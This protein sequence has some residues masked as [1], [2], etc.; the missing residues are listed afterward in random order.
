MT[1][2]IRAPWGTVLRTACVVSLVLMAA[3]AGCFGGDAG[4]KEGSPSPS[5]TPTGG[6]E[7][8]TVRV[9]ILEYPTNATANGTIN[10]TWQVEPETNV[11]TPLTHTGVHY[12][13]QSVPEANETSDEE[14]PNSAGEQSVGTAPGTFNAS[15]VADESGILYLRA[16]AEVGGNVSWSEEVQ[17]DV[18]GEGAAGELNTVRITNGVLSALSSFS[19]SRVEIKVGDSVQWKN[20]DDT[21]HTATA[22]DGSFDTGNI[23]AGNVSKVIVFSKEGAFAYRCTIHPQTMIGEVV[24]RA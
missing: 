13:N 23:A 24:V 19:P 17:I 21:T 14:Y 20:E 5:P 9:T 3:A 15:F 12:G 7:T 6:N 4:P 2:E 1:L 18:Q 10:I 16:H 8:G 11:T 22:R